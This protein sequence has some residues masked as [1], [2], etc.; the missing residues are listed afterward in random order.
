MLV[1]GVETVSVIEWIHNGHISCQA[2][3][4]AARQLRS[5]EQVLGMKLLLN[6]ATLPGSRA[7]K[8]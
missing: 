2:D 4:C 3:I 8:N 7:A 5:G 6:D 1:A